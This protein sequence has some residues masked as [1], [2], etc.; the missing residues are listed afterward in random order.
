VFDWIVSQHKGSLSDQRDLPPDDWIMRRYK[1]AVHDRASLA[2]FIEDHM[3]E[4]VAPPAASV[5][6]AWIEKLFGRVGNS[7]TH[8]LI[9]G[10]Q[11][12]GKS[13]K[14]MTKIPT[15]YENDPG[16]IFFSSPSIQQAN[17]KIK[18]FERMNKDERFVP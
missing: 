3:V 13:T 4:M 6:P 17:E 1:A 7:N 11:G 10:P 14:A 9:R 18:T 15:I 2:Q 5:T 16:V 12:C 8:V